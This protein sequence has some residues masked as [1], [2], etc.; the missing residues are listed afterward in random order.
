MPLIVRWPETVAAGS[1]ST[2]MVSNLDLAETFLDIAGVAIPSDMQGRSLTPILRGTAPPDWRTSFY[3]HYYEFPGWHDV[4]RHYGVRTETHKLIYF[5]TLD[6]WELY[7]LEK[8][9]DELTSVYEDP[10]YANVVAELKAE[11]ERLREHYTVPD[12]NRPLTD[13]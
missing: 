3:Y 9:P 6:E 13:G 2:A 7:D 4:A 1:E 11:L 5:Y 8:D 10:E 12:D